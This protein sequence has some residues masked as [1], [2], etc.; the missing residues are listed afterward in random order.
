MCFQPQSLYSQKKV[1]P[2]PPPI[3]QRALR[4]PWPSPE[5]IL[6]PEYEVPPGE[7]ACGRFLPRLSSLSPRPEVFN[8]HGPIDLGILGFFF[9]FFGGGGVCALVS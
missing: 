5:S 1:C 3:F 9:A 7:A 8:V 6:H 4:P 2:R